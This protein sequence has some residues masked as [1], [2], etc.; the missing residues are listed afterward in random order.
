M[1]V[2]TN[3]FI[4]CLFMI[5]QS[6]LTNVNR[7]KLQFIILQNYQNAVEVLFIVSSF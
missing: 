7:Y 5:V 2:S 6:A 1:L 4:N 3:A